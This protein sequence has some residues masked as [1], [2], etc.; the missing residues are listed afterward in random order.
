MTK[1]EKKKL[2][3][4]T[5]ATPSEKKYEKNEL[6]KST[7]FSKIEADFLGAYLSDGAYSIAEAKQLLI[8]LRKEKVK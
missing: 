4:E 2:E 7:E 8:K 5:K 6:L 1:K 3:V